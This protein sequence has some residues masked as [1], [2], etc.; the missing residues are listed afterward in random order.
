VDEEQLEQ[1]RE[2]QRNL[3]RMHRYIDRTDRLTLLMAYVSIAA[4]LVGVQQ[5]GTIAVLCA[6]V[7]AFCGYLAGVTAVQRRL[8][9]QAFVD[10]HAAYQ[11]IELQHL[12]EEG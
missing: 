4:A 9:H 11:E 5:G 1:V 3:E 7:I 6:A 2:L 10:L 12:I 8:R